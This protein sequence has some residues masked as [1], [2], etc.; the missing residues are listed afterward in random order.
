[1]DGNDSLGVFGDYV[2]VYIVHFVKSKLIKSFFLNLHP[3]PVVAAAILDPSV[4]IITNLI[5]VYQ[6]I[7]TVSY[8]SEQQPCSEGGVIRCVVTIRCC[9]VLHSCGNMFVKCSF[10]RNYIYV[11]FYGTIANIGFVSLLLLLWGW[12]ETQN[13]F[14][15]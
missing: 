3:L 15:E 4:Y 9:V 1:M 11:I 8:T 7:H 14:H 6:S 12:K 2:K 5:I 13:M 10:M